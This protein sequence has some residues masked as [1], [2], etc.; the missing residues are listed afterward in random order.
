MNKTARTVVASLLATGLAV[1]AGVS[2]QQSV[3]TPTARELNKSFDADQAQWAA[4][5][6]HEGRAIYDNRYAILDELGLRPGLHV[7]DIGAG[8]GLLSRLIAGRV[9]PD[10]IVYA[11]DIAKN[12]VDYIT[13]TAREQGIGNIV[14]VLG[15]P[16]SPKLAPASVDRVVIIDS[17]HHFE[18]PAEMLAEIK[19]ALKPGGLLV[20]V[21]FKRIENVSAPYV[22]KMVRAGQGT[23]T[24]EFLNAG[25]ELVE[26]REDI[27]PDNYLLKFSHRQ[28]AP[29]PALH[30]ERPPQR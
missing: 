18:F 6:E 26:R 4:R 16:R 9:G 28:A 8:S 24:D 21:D 15:D 7:A 30:G 14:P 1:G 19:R 3:I 17:Y 29:K 22:L 25:F 27:T 2:A 5:F 13:K 12:M 23:F 20:L 10:G 11:V